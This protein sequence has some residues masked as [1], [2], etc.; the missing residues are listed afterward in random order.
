[1]KIVEADVHELLTQAHRRWIETRDPK[2]GNRFA[3]L[4][5]RLSAVSRPHKD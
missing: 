3:A 1:M 4:V 5:W 2:D